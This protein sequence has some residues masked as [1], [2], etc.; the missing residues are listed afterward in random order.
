MRAAARPPIDAESFLP[1]LAAG[2]LDICLAYVEREDARGAADAARNCRLA[3]AL[4]HCGRRD[5]ALECVRRALPWAGDDAALLHICAWVFSNCGCHAEAASSYRRLIELYPDE[6]EFYRHASGSLAAT[7][8]LDEAIADGKRASDLAPQNPEFALHVGSLLLRAGRNDEAASYIGRAVALEPDNAR[9]L[10]ELST[11]CHALNRGE[12][13]IALALR[14]AALNPGDRGIAIHAA[15]LLIGCGRAAEATALLRGVAADGADPRLL[16]VLSAAEMVRGRLDAAVDAIDQ[17]LAAAPDVAEYHIHRGHLLWRQGDIAG[18]AMA[19]ERAAALDPT[20][21]ELKRAQMSLYLAAGL[22]TEA[23]VVGGELLHRFPEDRISA[24]AVM[25]L[26]THRLDTIEGEY[27][28]LSDATDRGMRLPP[29]PPGMIERL[30]AQRRVIGALI[31]RETRTRFADAKLGYGWALI[32]P[33]LHISLLSVTFAV[34]MQGR[35]PIGTHF[36][37]FYYTGLIRY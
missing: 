6:I 30:R 4:F 22:V 12:T 36:F 11:A 34:L 33:I 14:A 10:C 25:H 16:R 15:E 9:A 3:E 18:A 26:L 8:Q 21:P 35:P 20:S 1:A 29:P 19:L 27:V 17:A 23:T 13:A 7:G 28:V 37:I 24:E 31:I 5:E 32:E 2:R